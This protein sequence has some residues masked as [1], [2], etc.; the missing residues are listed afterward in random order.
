MIGVLAV[1][2]L[3]GLSA[4]LLPKAFVHGDVPPSEPENLVATSADSNISATW[5]EPAEKG[6]G[7][8]L[9]YSVEL[10][11]QTTGESAKD[12]TSKTFFTFY[13][14]SEGN[15]TLTVVAQND[16][17][18]STPVVADVVLV[19]PPLAPTGLTYSEE[20]ATS[21]LINLTWDAPDVA[22]EAY[23]IYITN[24]ERT[25]TE[26]VVDGNSYSWTSS[27]LPS[28][29]YSVSL[30]AEN[31]KGEL[32]SA[33]TETIRLVLG[34]IGDGGGPV[35]A[36][37]GP[38]NLIYNSENAAAGKLSLDWDDDTTKNVVAYYVSIV[39]ERDIIASETLEVNTT[40]YE[41]SLPDGLYNVI[42]FAAYGDGENVSS[43]LD[44]IVIT[45]T[46]GSGEAIVPQNLAYDKTEAAK[47]TLLLTWDADTTGNIAGYDVVISQHK[48]QVA[49]GSVKAGI[50]QYETTLEPGD[51]YVLVT[52]IYKD[53]TTASSSLETVTLGESK[54]GDSK[55][56]IIKSAVS[57]LEDISSVQVGWTTD[58]LADSLLEYGPG[59]LFIDS[60]QFVS[61]LVTNHAITLTKLFPCTIYN[62][63]ITSSNNLTT[64]TDDTR[65]FITKGCVKDSQVRN[66]SVK[67]VRS[68]KSD[69]LLLV[70]QDNSK[71]VGTI[72]IQ[73]PVAKDAE[74]VVFEMKQ[75]AIDSTS[76]FE[77]ET[78]KL[79]DGKIFDIKAFSG[80]ET[81]VETFE[82]PVQ[83]TLD[84]IP[85]ELAKNIDISTL[86]I[87]HSDDG[88]KSWSELPNCNTTI[89]SKNDSGQVTCDTVEFSLFA[90]FG[91][92]TQDS[93]T[94]EESKPKNKIL[95]GS[96]AGI[97]SKAQQ[98][99]SSGEKVDVLPKFLFSK[100]LYLGLSDP[101][102]KVLQKTLNSLGFVISTYGP[103]SVGNETNYFGE[104]T[105]QAVV[106]FQEARASE[107]LAPYGFRKGT[108][109]VGPYTREILNKLSK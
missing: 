109:R 13:G 90:I 60:K 52:A 93:G 103:G 92:P 45:S 24:P 84:F 102:V 43:S 22:V 20:S 23:R 74:S 30:V 88:G 94:N 26:E 49:G 98:V 59:K 91:Q 67:D 100:D 68:D 55:I 54:G 75:L 32:K 78:R 15:Y 70:D 50:N 21:N 14:L 71:Q 41:T 79:A 9:N 86:A 27:T 47:N 2:A 108:G 7:T 85:S 104:K 51:Y 96:F 31:N 28:G 16:F 25:T 56:S 64:T 46:G 72:S 5:S 6:D 69:T 97:L 63:R 101:D 19:N 33:P 80:P 77:K 89:D 76:E 44:G 8:Y 37:V 82:N 95:S 106:R 48:E 62:Y 57:F 38:Q 42:V 1:A 11:N 36:K 66:Y 40:F 65:Y 17:G 99:P 58:V 18:S 61:D 39:Q 4:F 34:E 107:I 73:Q 10:Y 12:R 83:I 29:T 53:K 81:K 3:I 87:W 105:K 35:P